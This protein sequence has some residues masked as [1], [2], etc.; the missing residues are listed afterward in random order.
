MKIDVV[1]PK[2]VSKSINIIVAQIERR[3]EYVSRADA[4]GSKKQELLVR[5][6]F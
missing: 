6:T 2:K 4:F 1:S 5:R 3:S